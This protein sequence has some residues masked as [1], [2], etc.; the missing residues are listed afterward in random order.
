MCRTYI[1][2]LRKVMQMGVNSLRETFIRGSLPGF[3]WQCCAR[4]ALPASRRDPT[5]GL[6]RP[7]TAETSF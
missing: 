4:P 5:L 6:Q 3:P 2:P 1:A 7:V